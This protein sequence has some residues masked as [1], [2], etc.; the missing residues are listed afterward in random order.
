MTSS[1]CGELG[2]GVAARFLTAANLTG[3]RADAFVLAKAAGLYL[4]P[5][6]GPAPGLVGDDLHFDASASEASTEAFVAD[7]VARRVLQWARVAVTPS[8][9]QS[10]AFALLDG[11]RQPR[12][13]ALGAA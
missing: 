8:A 3:K 6:M 7:C 11:W 2:S 1:Q 4:V 5:E 12:A 10:V 9:L 13:R